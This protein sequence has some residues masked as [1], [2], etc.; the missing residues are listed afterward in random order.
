MWVLAAVLFFLQ[1]PDYY[2][3]GMKALE[4]AKY[5]QAADLFAKAIASD[6]KD[7]AAH[8]HLALSYTMLKRDPQSL[9][10][11]KKVLELKPGLYEAEL[12]AGILLLRDKQPAGAE[13]YLKAAAAQKPKELRPR[14]YW[15]D[16]LLATGDA[17]QAQEQYHAALDLDAKS[18]AAELG[19][20]HALVRQDR[21][22]D[23]APHFQAAAHLDPAYRDA[24]LELAALYETNKQNAEA[25]AIYQQFPENSAAQEHIGRLLLANQ[26]SAEAIA[27]LEAAMQRDPTPANRLALATAYLFEKQ[28]AKAMPLLDQSVAGEP[29]NYSLRMMYGRGLRDTKKYDPAAQQF[30]QA[31]KLKPDS[32]EA[33]DELAGMLYMLEKYPESIGALDRAHQLGDDTPANY[34]FHAITYDKLKALKPALEYYQEFLSRSRGQ[35]PDEEW[36]AR[37][38]AKL[39]D[40]ELNHK[41]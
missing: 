28:Y 30:F 41:R 18:A 35:F 12:N 9:A 2:A 13:P 1:T 26:H 31:T 14:L 3:E 22:A 5:D 15:A 20:A 16:A 33:W 24:L 37:Q 23:A 29:S 27:P 11:Y 4:A 39:L 32:R 38:R 40:R 8:F 7:Y 6:P 34:Y 21:L 25:L 17:A 10:E 36:K 19:L